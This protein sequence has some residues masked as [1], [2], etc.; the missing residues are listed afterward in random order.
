MVCPGITV[1]P[2]AGF[3]VLTTVTF[4][5]EPTVKHSFESMACPAVLLSDEPR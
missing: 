4:G 1:V 5:A 3:E 2:V